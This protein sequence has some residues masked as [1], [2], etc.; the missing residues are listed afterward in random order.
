MTSRRPSK[1]AK[2]SG[3]YRQK[4]KLGMCPYPYDRNAKSFQMGAWRNQDPTQRA[5]NQRALSYQGKPLPPER[6]PAHR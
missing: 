6:Q 3:R 5:I 2:G 4:V 1:G